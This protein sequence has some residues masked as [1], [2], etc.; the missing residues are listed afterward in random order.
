MRLTSLLS[1]LAFS[2]LACGDDTTST[3][4]G[5]GAGASA[6]GAGGVGAGGEGAGD[7]GGGGAASGGGG[8]GGVGGTGGAGAAGGS[9]G[10]GGGEH[11]ACDVLPVNDEL[12]DECTSTQTF[13]APRAE[14]TLC[15]A[16][17]GEFWPGVVFTVPVPAGACVEFAADNVG[18]ALGA[19][20][21]ASIVDPSGGSL[22]FD[23]EMPCTV[24]NPDGFA[25]PRGAVT[26][27]EAGDALIVVGAW[28]GAGCD[29]LAST[30]FELSVTIDGVDVDLTAAPVCA[31][32]L[33]TII[34]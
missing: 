5:G 7:E 27:Q 22:Y 19:D 14:T 1:V 12:L 23:E 34:P 2:M 6:Q 24:E 21:F 4:G 31:G 32:D 20:L 10:S 8:I 33:L 17:S 3:S 18:S 25:C 29:P 15:T 28:E 16:D 13:G 30:A 9:G 26:T 11:P